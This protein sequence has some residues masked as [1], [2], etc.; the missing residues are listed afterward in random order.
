MP[1]GEEFRFFLL[2]FVV[3]TL[4][5]QQKNFN[6]YTF[7]ISVA[8]SISDFHH[9]TTKFLLKPPGGTYSIDARLESFAKKSC[10]FA[11]NVI[12]IIKFG[13]ILRKH[14][15]LTTTYNK[16]IGR[17]YHTSSLF[18]Y[19]YVVIK[20]CMYMYTVPLDSW[21]YPF[22]VAYV[23][24]K[25]P[26]STSVSPNE[27]P[28]GPSQLPEAVETCVAL[29]YE[30]IQNGKCFPFVIREKTLEMDLEV[31]FFGQQNQYINEVSVFL[32]VPSF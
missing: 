25:T 4:W 20:L 14:M 5:D 18:L 19:M 17:C 12:R 23:M 1:R 13:H 3:K 15:F 9:S 24:S 16:N 32:I 7:T 11:F 8:D 6:E 2:F 22:Q 10:L 26:R 30:G 31:L 27:A 29:W 28:S 21:R